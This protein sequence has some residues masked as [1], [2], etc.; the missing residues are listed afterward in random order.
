MNRARVK[1]MQDYMR[2]RW[3]P[4]KVQPRVCYD[5]FF[6]R[7]R[8][9]RTK[10]KEEK[11]NRERLQKNEQFFYRLFFLTTYERWNGERRGTQTPKPN[12]TINAILLRP[13]LRPIRGLPEGLQGPR[14]RRAVSWLRKDSWTMPPFLPPVPQK[15][16]LSA[17][18]WCV[19]SFFFARYS[20]RF[21]FFFFCIQ[22]NETPKLAKRWK[23]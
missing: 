14:T 15:P 2:K 21:L 17:F 20:V 8:F 11:K 12:L 9:K 16:P 18:F 1:Q 10:K 13:S 5:R 23:K 3:A 22:K 6:P 19:F 7:L 4:K